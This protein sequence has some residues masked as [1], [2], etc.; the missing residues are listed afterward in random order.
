M[1]LR[2]VPRAPSRSSILTARHIRQ[3]KQGGVLYVTIPEKHPVFSH[4]LEDAGYQVGYTGKGWG[5]GNLTAGGLSRDPIGKEYNEIQMKSAPFGYTE[6][7]R[8]YEDGIGLKSGK[9]LADATVPKFWPDTDLERSYILDYAY[10]IE[11]MD[12]HLQR[13][14]DKLS[15]LGALDNTLVMVTSDNSMPFPRAKVN[16][17]DHGI[18]MPLAIRWPKKI[19]AER[20]IDDFSS[21]IDLAPTFLEAANIAPPK[22]MI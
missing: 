2:L 9:K 5:P 22:E 14:L 6:P 8:V 13:M 16:L 1:R 21:H 19:P 12:A 15:Q 7:H 3:I 20:V 11:W 17:Y 4:L 10:E 18:R